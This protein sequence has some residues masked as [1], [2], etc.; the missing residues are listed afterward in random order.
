M[1]RRRGALLA[2]ASRARAGTIATTT[3]ATST[4]TT[5]NATTN[6]ARATLGATHG[7]RAYASDE[8]ARAH[9]NLADADRIFTNL[10][11]TRDAFLKGAMARGD[12]S[13][14]HI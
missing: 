11:G 1:F 7:R 9:G 6:A 4:T 5:T 8:P 3:N 13:L 12:L 10:Y 2:L 14:I